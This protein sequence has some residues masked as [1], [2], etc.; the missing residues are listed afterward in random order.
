MK[1]KIR[2]Y[3]KRHGMTLQS[4]AQKIGTTPQT[5]QRLE[6]QNMTVSTDWL[7]R[8]AAVFEVHPADLLERETATQIMHLGHIDKTGKIF[9]ANIEQIENLQL[10]IKLNHAIAA[11]LL[12]DIGSFAPNTL[13]IAEQ[14]ANDDQHH[15]Q[16]K[17]CIVIQNEDQAHVGRVFITGDDELCVVPSDETAMSITLARPVR[18]A[19]IRLAIQTF[20]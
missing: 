8:F 13:L 20:E 12:E 15:A 6:T 17:Q 11:L 7:E 9:P 19:I 1:T 10:S 18:I 16:D 5:V 2:E 3:R 14:I 4:L